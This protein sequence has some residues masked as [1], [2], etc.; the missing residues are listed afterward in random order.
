[1]VLTSVLLIVA[2]G[3]LLLA[4]LLFYAWWRIEYL[5]LLVL[6]ILINYVNPMAIRFRHLGSGIIE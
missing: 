3:L 4:S 6:S 2:I 1:M 5:A